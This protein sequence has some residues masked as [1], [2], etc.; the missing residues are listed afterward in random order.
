MEDWATKGVDFKHHLYVPET[1][2]TTGE[3]HH[4]RADHCHLLKR[5]ASECIFLCKRGVWHFA[6]SPANVVVSTL[7]IFCDYLYFHCQAIQGIYAMQN[8]RRI[9]SSQPWWPLILG[10]HMQPWLVSASSLWLMPRDSSHTEFLRQGYNVAAEYVSVI[11]HWHEA[12]DGRG[13]SEL[14]RAQ[15]NQQMLKYL[16]QDFM[17]WY[18]QVQDF[19]LLD[20][21]RWEL[22]VL[23]LIGNCWE[24]KFFRSVTVHYMH[25]QSCWQE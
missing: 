6:S 15:K 11:A 25:I 2:K 14:S 8:W 18:D 22:N 16:L 17:P 10:W 20:I 19:S 24:C 4:E 3:L 23:C 13:L 9:H 12:S 1:D 7:L 21:N 5:I